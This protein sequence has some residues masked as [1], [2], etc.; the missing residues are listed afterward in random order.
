MSKLFPIIISIIIVF[1]ACNVKDD[2]KIELSKPVVTH[3]EELSSAS[4][5]DVIGNHIYIV[6]D[7]TPFLFKLDDSLQIID[8]Y[9][10]S[11]I[12]SLDKGRTPKNIKADFEGMAVNNRD[13]DNALYIISSGSTILTRDTSYVFDTKTLNISNSRN[14]REL[15]K[16]IKQ[17]ANISNNNEI[18][19]EGI[20]FS[21]THVFLFH[22]GN[23]SDN[24]IVRIY[25]EDYINYLNHSSY[26]PN[27]DIYRFDLPVY[28]GINSGFSGACLSPDKSGLIFTAS[29]E[30][31]SDEVN[32]GRVIG[33]YIGYISF[34]D[35]SKGK[36]TSVLL[37]SN[38]KILSKKLEGVSILGS[39]VID[40]ITT[41]NLI[42]V[43][44]NDDG[45]S[46]IIKLEMKL[47]KN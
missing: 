33:S 16:E 44:D 46:D 42:T 12:D 27:I 23:I 6:G 47:F 19:I 7:D 40:N 29:L 20:A 9:K 41:C 4:G 18:N 13:T 45:T 8:R 24:F 15:F 25:K 1:S 10:I 21:D 30:D 14:I 36:Y 39:E 31:T 32:D 28:D 5:I 17:K 38:N 37:T 22:R 2:L 3:L 26:V 43:C 11:Q 35:L 34:F